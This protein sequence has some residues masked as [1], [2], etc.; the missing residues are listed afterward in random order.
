VVKFD[1]ET[2]KLTLSQRPT[3]RGLLRPPGDPGNARP[4]L[5]RGPPR[6]NRPNWEQNAPPSGSGLLG[7]YFNKKIVV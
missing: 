5:E 6:S 3:P 4:I 7:A 2:G 1:S